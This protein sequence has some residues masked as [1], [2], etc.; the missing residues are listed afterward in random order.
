MVKRLGRRGRHT[1]LPLVGDTLVELCLGTHRSTTLVFEDTDGGQSEL[2]LEDAV[3]LRRGRD[4]RVLDGAKPGA[5]YN[6]KLLSPLLE[7]L[8]GRVTDAIAE[9]GGLL[10]ITFSD[11]LDLVVVP[12]TGHESWHYRH[13]RPGRPVG[14]SLARPL[15]VTGCHGHLI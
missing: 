5:T 12:S 15:S 8:D 10:R 14:G 4:E 2:V 11:G 9:E 6:P 3:L 13:P 1:V 7:L